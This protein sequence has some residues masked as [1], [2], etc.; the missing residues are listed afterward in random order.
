MYNDYFSKVKFGKL[1]NKF[2]VILIIK[3]GSTILPI[4]IS[5]CIDGRGNIGERHEGSDVLLCF[6]LAQNVGWIWMNEETTVVVRI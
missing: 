6:N 5:G 2:K 1:R 3:W 4:K